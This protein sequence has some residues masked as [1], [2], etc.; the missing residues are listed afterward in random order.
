[1]EPVNFIPIAEAG[2]LIHTMG[3]WTI[4]EACS[5]ILKG[6][7][8]GLPMVPMAINVS[9]KQFFDMGFVNGVAQA[10]ADSGVAPRYVHLDIPVSTLNDD[11]GAAAAILE[12]LKGRGFRTEVDDFGQGTFSQESL[13][14]LPI[15]AL[16]V[17][18]R[19]CSMAQ[20]D[21][22][23]EL[24]QTS[25]V[26]IIAEQIESVDEL[27][28][29]RQRKCGLQGYQLCRPIRGNAFPEWYAHRL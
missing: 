14:R 27:E 18:V 29:L 2:G 10:I 9:P 20:L 19:N 13:R 7:E 16:K 8:Q 11:F 12:E 5:Q 1:M 17:N 26:D 15:N 23:L 25:G 6:V 22:I 24:G 21:A 28:L 4:K 3:E